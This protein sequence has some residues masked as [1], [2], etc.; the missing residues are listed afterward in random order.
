MLR[1]V[2]ST[3]M[4]MIYQ[5]YY[6]GGDTVNYFKD[7]RVMS[8]A[9][10]ESPV[11]L[12]HF[13]LVDAREFDPAIVKY[14][15]KLQF[16]IDNSSLL[17]AKF[18]AIINL[19]TFNSFLLTS[20]IFGI[21]GLTGTWALFLTFNKIEPSLYKYFAIATLYMPS[22]FFWGAGLLKDTLVL[23]S[24]GWMIYAFYSLCIERKNPTSNL[25]I[26]FIATYLIV[27]LKIYIAMCL[28]PSLAIWVILE[29]N[30]KIKSKVLKNILKPLL[31]GISVLIGLFAVYKITENDSK[32]NLD[33]LLETSRIT[34]EYIAQVSISNGGS[35]Y[36]IGE[37]DYTSPLGLLKVL[38]SAIIVSLYRPFIWE[39]KNPLMLISS[40]ES[41]FFLILT[42]IV[43]YR[44]GFIRSFAIINKTPFLLSSFIFIIAFAFSIGIST[45]NFGTLARYKLPLV[46]MLLAALYYLRFKGENE[47]RARFSKSKNTMLFQAN[48]LS[49]Q[50]N[51]GDAKIKPI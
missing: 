39:V 36:S 43:F 10:V 6:N 31:I 15:N 42:F 27:S 28:I 2:G 33:E 46:P 3:M 23:S 5:F 38:P 18:S 48:S 44:T 11:N 1:F 26:I 9:I 41:G 24:M 49:S 34:A 4:V 37:I 29:Y 13:I 12:I 50:A 22:V 8:N 19:F 20:I 30:Y 21:I 32:Y 45:M 51:K 35:Y 14:T 16:F 17:V 40:L 7:S 25:L 47:A